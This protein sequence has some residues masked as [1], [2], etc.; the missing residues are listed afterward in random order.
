[1]SIY[2]NFIF[3]IIIMF[4][5][6]KVIELLFILSG[7]LVLLSKTS[8]WMNWVMR[9]ALLYR[10]PAISPGPLITTGKNSDQLILPRWILNWP[11]IISQKDSFRKMLR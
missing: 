9:R 10:S 4:W 7:L 2:V 6:A 1:M 8:F 3:Y 5:C 11:W